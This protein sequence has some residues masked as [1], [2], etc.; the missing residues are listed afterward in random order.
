MLPG[1]LVLAL[2]QLKDSAWDLWWRPIALL[3]FSYALQWLGHRIEGNDMGEV[4]LLKRALGLPYV[5]IS[6]RYAIDMAN[7]STPKSSP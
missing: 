3:A 6:P 2:L 7:H 1:A 5:R 4:I